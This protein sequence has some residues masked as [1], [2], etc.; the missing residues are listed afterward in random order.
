[1]RLVGDGDKPN[2]GK[3]IVVRLLVGDGLDAR[4][5]DG[6]FTCNALVSEFDN[7]ESLLIDQLSASAE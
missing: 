6:K 4:P 7:S 1:M 2:G 3:R 5:V